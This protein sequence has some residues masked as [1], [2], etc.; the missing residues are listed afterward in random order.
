MDGVSNTLLS[1]GQQ[2]QQQQPQQQ[3]SVDMHNLR[4]GQ[5]WVVQRFASSDTAAENALRGG[6]Y[7][8]LFHREHEGYMVSTLNTEPLRKQNYPLDEILAKAAEG[9]DNVVRIKPSG[10]MQRTTLSHSSIAVWQLQLQQVQSGERTACRFRPRRRRVPRRGVC[11]GRH[12]IVTTMERSDASNVF[13]LLQIDADAESRHVSVGSY[14]R[15]R[16]RDTGRYLGID[17]DSVDVRTA[18][19]IAGATPGRLRERMP[20]A[21][22]GTT[23]GRDGPLPTGASGQYHPRTG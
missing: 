18:Q 13:Y 14:V 12:E 23:P 11:G 17:D 7:V 5:G 10:M 20:G 9:T 21:T 2:Q 19:G 16:H 1:A 4:S 6:A 3:Q 8:R 22:W 15:V